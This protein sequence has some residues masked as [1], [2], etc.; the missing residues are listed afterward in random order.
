[1]N[2]LRFEKISKFDRKREPATVSFPFAE[3][4]LSDPN[5]LIVTDGGRELP[6]QRRILSTWPAGSVKW[7]L[8]HLQPDLPGNAGK[9]LRFEIVESP[10]GSAAPDV[11]VTAEKTER[12][13]VVDTGPL[14]FLVSYE[15]FLPLAEMRLDGKRLWKKNPFGGFRMS[16]GGRELSTDSTKVELELEETGPLRVVVLVRGKHRTASGEEFI[17]FRGRLTAY[18]G[19]P[20]IEVEH[21]FLHCEDEAELQ[22]SQLRLEFRPPETVGARVALG[23]G[24]Y[25]TAIRQGREPLEMALT[26]ETLLYQS[27]EHFEDCF[28][29]DFWA[30]WRGNGAGLAL[31]IHQAHQNFPKKL[32]VSAEG[33]VCWLFPTEA[34]PAILR[35]GMAKTHRIMLHFHDGNL[36]LEEVSSRSLQFQLPDRP[37]LS[38]EWY[39]ED[40]PWG[41]DF[42]PE[43]IPDRMLVRFAQMHDG[44]PRGLGMF[45]FGD[46][47][48][49]G[50]TDQGR[51]KG[52]TVWVNN[53]YDRAHACTLF[54]AFTGERRVLGS[55]LVSARHWLDVDLCHRSDDPLRRGGLVAHSAHHVTEVVTPSHEWVDGLLDYY[56]LTGRR[57]GLEG[58]VSIA[59]NVLRH[60]KQPHFRQP[61]ASSVR[62]IG[63]A[64]RT[65]VAIGRETGEERFLREAKRIADQLVMWHGQLGGMLA[66]YTS[67]SMPRVPFMISI[68]ANSLARYLLIEDDERVK[69]LIVK[70]ADDLLE[71]CI[72]PGGVLYYKEFPSLRTPAPTIHAVE[73]FTH[74][75]RFTGNRRYLKAAARQFAAV[76]DRGSGGMR[77]FKKFIEGDAVIRGVGAGRGFASNYTSLII[78]A[79]AAGKDGLLER[80]EYPI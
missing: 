22:L 69:K 17:D 7:L 13:I 45:H 78:F 41:M 34:P 77:S 68:A 39:R 14:S 71:H 80:F 38:R 1:M 4:R 79:S 43:Y 36:P 62:E 54:Y 48:D 26:A 58:A 72:G 53:E 51:G 37:A 46:A 70:T 31:S 56:H 24:Y 74:A 6:I 29:G 65:S 20:Y 76:L 67:H 21:Q 35:Q 28:Y 40:N 42:F 44:R 11:V 63:W 49:A 64:L 60:L 73:T 3:G 18:A 59:E 8:V 10:I 23:E 50:Y 9:E 52:A 75:H 32:E 47:P 12:G 57:E 2:T 30:N 33:I 66:P 5:R 19:K 25:R 15:G 55:A 61:G 27:N 16:C